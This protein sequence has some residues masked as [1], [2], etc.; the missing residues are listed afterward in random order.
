MK[1]DRTFKSQ[2]AIITKN[3]LL[4]EKNNNNL[5]MISFY[6]ASKVY[7]VKL[8]YNKLHDEIFNM[9]PNLVEFIKT[10]PDRR[11]QRLGMKQMAT[12]GNKN[13]VSKG[14]QSYGIY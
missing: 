12:S 10:K 6:K 5:G 1:K 8:S 14:G 9:N 4:K 7:P 11:E 3:T 2:A 13:Y